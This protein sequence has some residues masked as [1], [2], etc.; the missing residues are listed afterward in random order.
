MTL[1]NTKQSITISYSSACPDGY[2][3]SNCSYECQPPYYGTLCQKRCECFI[4]TC[5]FIHGCPLT[6]GRSTSKTCPRHRHLQLYCNI[7]QQWS[8]TVKIIATIWQ[9]NMS[10][11]EWK[12]DDWYTLHAILL[13]FYCIY[14]CWIKLDY[15]WPY[16]LWLHF[17]F[18][19]DTC[20]KYCSKYS[21][22]F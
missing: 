15:V 16:V 2:F 9:Y 21:K 8:I 12:C 6:T 4:S 1:N 18:T 10:E 7:Q 3:G 14:I 11:K 5:H 22:L 17:I 19:L 13:H 20:Y